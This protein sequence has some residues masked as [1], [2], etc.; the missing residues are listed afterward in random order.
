VRGPNRSLRPNKSVPARH[1][2]H[3]R[4]RRR[5]SLVESVPPPHPIPEEDVAS[6]V[7]R[8]SLALEQLSELFEAVNELHRK[9]AELHAV[10]AEPL[11]DLERSLRHARGQPPRQPD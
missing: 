4:E 9:L 5:T 1:L 11:V 7:I 3:G 8:I 2:W 10:L 6:A